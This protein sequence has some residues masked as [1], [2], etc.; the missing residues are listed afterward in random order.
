[1]VLTMPRE[2]YPSSYVCDCGQESHHF[3]DTIRE[4]KAESHRRRQTLVADDGEHKIIFRDGKMVAMYCP[5]AGKQLPAG[6]R[7]RGDARGSC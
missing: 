7:G 4:L 2:I 3:E 1:M 6:K 5:V